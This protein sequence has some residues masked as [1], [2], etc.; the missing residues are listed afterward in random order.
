MRSIVLPLPLVGHLKRSSVF[1]CHLQHLPRMTQ[2]MLFRTVS[3]LV[4]ACFGLAGAAFAQEVGTLTGRVFNPGTQEYVRDVEVS[5]DGTNLRVA[6][7]SG[8][9]FTLNNV[10]VGQHTVTVK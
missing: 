1:G 7:E 3:L 2:N 8:G 10:P 4:A 9:F 5:V 6:T